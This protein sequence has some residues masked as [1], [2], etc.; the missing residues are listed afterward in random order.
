MDYLGLIPLTT[1]RV[2]RYGDITGGS[3]IN[4]IITVISSATTGASVTGKD[5]VYL[6][7]GTFIFTL[8]TAVGNTNIYTLKVTDG[9]K[10]TLATTSGQTVDNVA[11]GTLTFPTSLD[12]ISNNANWFII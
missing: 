3:G 12:F 2:A 7:T 10:I 1:N 8:P 5:Y 11:P 6:T 4:R 9:G